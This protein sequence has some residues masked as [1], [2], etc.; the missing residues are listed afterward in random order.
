MNLKR[1]LLWTCL[2]LLLA[3]EF[4]LFSVNRQKDAAV[5]SLR[6]ARQQIDELQAQLKS[7]ENSNVVSQ[8]AEISRLRADNQN[9][10]RLRNRITQLQKTNQ[11]LSLELQTALTNAQAQQEQL[12]QL[13]E[14][15]LETEQEQ[16]Q[17]TEQL[18]AA[19]AADRKT[20]INNLRQI[21]AAKQAW[22]LENNKSE[23][24]I[25]T[26]RDLLPY[27]KNG[28]FPVCPDGGTYTIGAVGEKPTCSIPGHVLP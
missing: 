28:V 3:G 27:L 4:F 16:A 25:P 13:Q 7:L 8:S 14:E 24:A 6:E 21:D 11:E 12:Q 1:W 10:P 26:E 23:D 20:C 5:V 22:A 15:K 18:A 19:A 9:L 2:V 17:E